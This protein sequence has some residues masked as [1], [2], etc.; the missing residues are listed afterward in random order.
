MD[1]Q[2]A[3]AYILAK[4]KAELPAGRTYHSLEH[5]LDVYASAI[6]I[7]EEEGVTGEGL[8][9]LKIAAL[10]HD[11]GFTVQDIE[12]EEAGCRIARAVLPG[13][14]FNERQLE[15]ICDMI[16]ATH[17]PQ[18]PHNKLSRVLCDADL[19]YL[20]RGDFERIG[21]SLFQEMRTYGVLHTEKEWNELQERFLERHSYFTT[22]NKRTREPQKHVHLQG[23]REWLA[24]H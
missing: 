18:T 7:A 3:K 20:G 19:D 10:Y 24:S 6:S 13:F 23:V 17:I 21:R 1:T 15:L 5:T 11:S 22:T 9:L 2:G 8:V 14:G 4:L 16:M 12:H